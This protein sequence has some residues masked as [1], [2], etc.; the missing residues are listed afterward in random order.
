MFTGIG[1]LPTFPTNL[2]PPVEHIGTIS[3]LNPHDTSPSGGNGFSATI[4]SVGPILND[5]H[6]GDSISIN[7]SPPP[8][9]K[10]GLTQALV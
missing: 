9:L 8:T 4:S 3:S 6:L 10:P 5:V 2:T 1:P 7:G